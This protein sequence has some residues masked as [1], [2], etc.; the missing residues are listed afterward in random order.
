MTSFREGRPLLSIAM[1]CPIFADGLHGA[2]SRAGLDAERVYPVGIE[3]M[4]DADET[5]SRTIGVWLDFTTLSP[6]D[7]GR[8]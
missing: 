4:N 2:S 3:V 5:A 8:C 1:A 7:D 6:N